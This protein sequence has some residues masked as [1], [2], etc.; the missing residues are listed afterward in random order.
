MG[1][2][3]NA[4]QLVEMAVVGYVSQ[5]TVRGYITHASGEATILPGMSGMVYNVRVGDDAFGWAADHL[6]P[7]ASIAHPDLDADYAMHYLT[8]MGNQ[9]FVM[10]GLIKRHRGHRH[11]RTCAPAGG[12]SSRKPPK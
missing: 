8:C 11:R 2:A 10:S 12:F 7:G 3:T 9:A 6:E 1:L 5:P 4:D